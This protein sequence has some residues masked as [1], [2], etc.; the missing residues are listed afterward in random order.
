M[1]LSSGREYGWLDTFVE[2]V[3]GSILPRKLMK[4]RLDRS[5]KR[6]PPER[7]QKLFTSAEQAKKTNDPH[8][9]LYDERRISHVVRLILVLIIVALLVGPSAVLFFVPGQSTLK[10]CLIMVFTLFFALAMTICTKAKRHE[11]LAAT[12]T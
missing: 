8:L 7:R 9:Y 3:M 5:A 10:I 4:V 1:S 2:V 12:A 11:M 6:R